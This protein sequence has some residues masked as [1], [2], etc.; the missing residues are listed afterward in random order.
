VKF[1]VRRTSLFLFTVHFFSIN[2]QATLHPK[3]PRP[4]SISRESDFGNV[5]KFGERLS[6]LHRQMHDKFDRAKEDA[7]ALA[8]DRLIYPKPSLDP[9]DYPV[10]R[11]H[12]AQ[13]LLIL[14]L[15]AKKHKLPQMTPK[16]LRL[17]KPE[18]QLFPLPV[19]RS[20]I[21]KEE[22]KLKKRG[23]KKHGVRA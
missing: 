16:K 19:F 22:R 21:Y 12:E 2:I 10:W 15:I 9:R 11:G 13:R 23:R 18:Y 5:K 7:M 8:H 6:R 20:K 14:D 1:I 4:S 3:V 17:T